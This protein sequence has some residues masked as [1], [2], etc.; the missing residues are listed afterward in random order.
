MTNSNLIIY[1]KCHPPPTTNATHT[2]GSWCIDLSMKANLWPSEGCLPILWICQACW[3]AGPATIPS[4]ITLYTPELK[5]LLLCL[6]VMSLSGWRGSGPKWPCTIWDWVT[7]KVISIGLRALQSRQ[8]RAN[9]KGN[10]SNW[11]GNEG[12]YLWFNFYLRLFPVGFLKGSNHLLI[13]A[14]CYLMCVLWLLPYLFFPLNSPWAW[15][16][17][18]PHL[19]A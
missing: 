7:F 17:G 15:V 18:R 12:K 19:I 6:F 5:W 9:L 11:L 8:H 13:I 10:S 4:V 14:K 16:T 1:C 3:I 2:R